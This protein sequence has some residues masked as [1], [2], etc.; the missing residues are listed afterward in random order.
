MHP[1]L[2][3]KHEGKIVYI[4]GLIVDLPVQD[5]N[6]ARFI[7]K[8]QTVLAGDVELKALPQKIQTSWYKTQETIKPNQLWRLGLKLKAPH[9]FHNHGTFDY[10]FWLFQ[11]GIQAKA[12]VHKQ[13]PQQLI[14][15]KNNFSVDRYRYELSKWIASLDYLKH[16]SIY[17]ALI[18][19]DRSNISE[20]QWRV[21]RHTGTSHLIAISGL[22]ISLLV[23]LCYF[24]TRFICSRSMH[25]THFI[26]A[27]KAAIYVSLCVAIIYSALAG[28]SLPTLRAL[29]MLS[30]YFISRLFVKRLS[31]VNILAI[32]VFLILLLD[33]F[34][35][36]KADFWL[37]FTAV[38]LIGY[39]ITGRK[40]QSKLYLAFKIQVFLSFSLIPLTLWYFNLAT[41]NGVFANI[42][43][44]PFTG[45]ILLP[46]LFLSLL[47]SPFEFLQT[48]LLK[49]IDICVEY[50]WQFLNLLLSIDYN[51]LSNLNL[52][53][54]NKIA[55]LFMFF[56]CLLL[57]LPKGLPSRALALFC[58]VPMC[59]YHS[60]DLKEHELDFV[61]LDVGQGLAVLIQTKDETILFDTGA[62]FSETF[63]VGSDII[64][65]YLQNQGINTLDK[66][67]IS[68]GD[69]DHIG[70]LLGVTENIS[71]KQII[72]SVAY[73]AEFANH[74]FCEQGLN[75]ETNGYH[76][77][78]LHPTLNKV[79]ELSK[80]DSSCVL[81]I[82][83]RQ[84]K[85]LLTG[86]IERKA[87]Q[88][89]L[90]QYQEK[91]KADVMIVPH[92]GSRTSS[93]RHF[94]NQ[95]QP[96]IAL[97]SSGYSN[98][99]GFPKQDIVARY[100]KQ[101]GRVFNTAKQGAISL[102][103]SNNSYE[104]THSRDEYQRFWHHQS[105]TTDFK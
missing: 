4:E 35:L 23:S 67:I 42:I 86:D 71:V 103:F 69:N 49:T 89:L 31:I 105:H 99:F 47:L 39:L 104:L 73:Q 62:K 10:E 66:I 24:L 36:L 45:F 84:H 17:Q 60:N 29:I 102:F 52:N 101:G 43:A 80:N 53:G 78:F 13:Y 6:K 58:F 75:W 54:A 19:G 3:Q 74:I 33:P 88:M 5:N 91:L 77:E 2:A 25:T 46:G 72:S 16:T 96:D 56:A 18:V 37:S 92:H 70:G 32:A 68:H 20:E 9:G 50:F 15:D 14:K 38:A 81:M 41:L 59:F 98:R 28:F 100:E 12:Y 8:P 82:S 1:K 63:D 79:E 97:V 26:P 22:H 76:F 27:P 34:S 93:S 55:L 90:A 11:Q 48:F 64:V 61:M 85:I 87:E 51:L 30:V 44:V 65:P 94:I 95:V 40:Q 21:F 83:G 57:F 7:I